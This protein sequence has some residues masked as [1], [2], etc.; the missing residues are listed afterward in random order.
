MPTIAVKDASVV[1][2]FTPSCERIIYSWI[3]RSLFIDVF[4]YRYLM[5][6]LLDTRVLG[7]PFR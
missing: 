6:L 4:K 7:N 3:L 5:I 2:G 1:R